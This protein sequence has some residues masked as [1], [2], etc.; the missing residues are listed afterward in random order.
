MGLGVWRGDMWGPG[1]TVWRFGLL[2]HGAYMLV[3]S[4]GVPQY[5][6]QLRQATA[7]APMVPLGFLRFG[8]R[9]HGAYMLVMSAGV[10]QYVRQLRQETAAAPMV[11][12]GVS[13]F[14]PHCHGVDMV[15]ET[16]VSMVP[17]VSSRNPDT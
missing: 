11:P 12:L 7:A 8:P 6:G 3:V 4:V 9:C 16:A 10:P 5:V 13:R 2:C 1:D 15:E 14:G 17:L